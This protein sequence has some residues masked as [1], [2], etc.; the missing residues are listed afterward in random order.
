MLLFFLFFFPSLCHEASTSEVSAVFFFFLISVIRP[1]RAKRVF[2]F[3]TSEVSA[4][5]FFDFLSVL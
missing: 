3:S 2:F 5:F 1:V 4:V